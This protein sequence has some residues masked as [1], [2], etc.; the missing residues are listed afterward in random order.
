[1]TITMRTAGTSL[2]GQATGPG[3][4]ADVSRHMNAILEVSP[5]KR[6]ARVQPG[7]IRDQLNHQLKEHGLFFAPDTSTTNRCMIGGMAANNSCGS[8]SIKYGTTREHLLEIK[9][10][11]DDGSF[12]VFKPLTEKELNEKRTLETR[13][14]EIYRR[15]YSLLR[16]NRNLIFDKAPHPEVFRRNTGYALD[17]LCEMHPF[18][19]GGRPF[20]MCELLAG[21]E[22]TLALFSELL[23]SLTPAPSQKVLVISQFNRLDDALEATVMAVKHKPAAVELADKKVLDAT[24]GNPLHR[25]N[26]FFLYGDPH[27][28][29]ITEFHGTESDGVSGRATVLLD[30]LQNS[31]A[32]SF[33]SLFLKEEEMKRIW[34]LRKAGLGLLMGHLSDANSPEFVD[35]TAVRVEDLPSYIREFRKIMEKH[36]LDCVY[37]AHASAGELHLRP[38][39]N[40]K[41]REG[42][43]KMK[44]VAQET[45]DLVKKYRGS[46]SGE[47][48]D[49]R[50]RAHLIESTYG[51]ELY[52]LFKQV[53][54]I[55]D[56]DYLFNK[57][58]IISPPPMDHQLRYSPEWKDIEVPTIFKW[59]ET[60][61]FGKALEACNGAAEC[62]KLTFSGGMMCPSYRATLNEIDSTRGRANLLRQLFSRDSADAF[63]SKEIREALSLCLSCK[64]CKTECPANVDMAKLKAEFTHGWHERRGIP[65]D[66]R[67]FGNPFG[68]YPLASMFPRLTNFSL[69]S[70]LI[71]GLLSRSI[72]LAPERS[73]PDFAPKSFISLLREQDLP[74]V[75]PSGIPGVVLLADYFNTY[76]DP[77][78]PLAALNLFK[79]LGV[80]VHVQV[81]FSSGRTQLSRGL[82]K[83][84]KSIAK[85]KILELHPFVQKG[86][87]ITGLEPGEV[88]TLRDEYPDFFSG[89]L[90]QKALELQQSTLLFEEL[91]LTDTFLPLLQK[92]VNGNGQP[93]LLQNHCHSIQLGNEDALKNLFEATGYQPSVLSSGCCG[94]AGSFGY[95][96]KNYAVSMDIGSLELFPAVEKAAPE[97]Q[98][99]APGFSCRHQIHDGTGRNPSHPAEILWKQRNRSESE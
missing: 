39:L 56:P 81:P 27:A 35:D 1:L 11:L 97:S 88:L 29:L 89:S 21:S 86:F 53:K 84:A 19:E 36:G 44:A 32:D 7:V 17:K 75:K 90:H 68:I 48:G 66:D 30:E 22:G 57:G 5:E 80:P 87:L 20:N 9:A 23:V 37:Y 45:A 16:D 40:L 58:K 67:F 42:L 96:K 3:V 4:I 46:L 38:I 85:S 76:H 24:K 50:L 31:F 61:G 73:L 99:C 95:Q 14:G 79:L 13:E 12:V 15:M 77:Q 47:H 52:Q 72:G 60:K 93:V 62:R 83:Q 70:R 63:S 33:H 59:Q 94:M 69:K 41:T 92:T 55:W 65:A 91:L 18:T 2:A 28:I 34:D 74:S 51:T 98:I 8:Y 25:R 54:E 49:G 82:L 71:K 78:I 6:T 10:V 43:E 26:R 64:A